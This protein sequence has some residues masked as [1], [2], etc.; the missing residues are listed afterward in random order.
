MLSF[1]VHSAED[2]T[3]AYTTTNKKTQKIL[4][5][6]DENALTYDLLRHAETQENCDFRQETTDLWKKVK[7]KQISLADQQEQLKMLI[8]Q[9]STEL[10]PW[11]QALA[12]RLDLGNQP[13]FWDRLDK[14]IGSTL[15]T[16]LKIAAAVCIVTTFAIVPVAAA[17]IP[18]ASFQNSCKNI[19]TT[20]YKSTDSNLQNLVHL[21]ADC[22]YDR[23]AH[24]YLS[25]TVILPK[26]ALSCLSNNNGSI[27]ASTLSDC[28]LLEGSF[29]QTCSS[30][31]T[32][33]YL[34]SDSSIPRGSICQYS[35][36]CKPVGSNSAT[37]P[38]TFYLHKAAAACQANRLENCNG[39][40][41][42]REPGESDN[43]C[44]QTG[45]KDRDE[46]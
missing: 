34:S 16:T 19:A 36:N 46:L 7:D 32:V 28:P 3:I 35:V 14:K 9:Y 6:S 45:H 31:S 13:P 26:N 2:L 8:H 42:Q 1:V 23:A 4:K 29:T 10:S 27:T 41:V 30:P 21:K 37:V 17:I 15:T 44:E 20:P 22:A 43:K 12:E 40:L 11:Q 18:M 24:G 5:I 25:N 38:N 33:E 39:R